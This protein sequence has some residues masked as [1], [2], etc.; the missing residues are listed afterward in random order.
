MSLK[1]SFLTHLIFLLVQP[2]S[3]G[4]I[5]KGDLKQGERDST[6]SERMKERHTQ[7][8]RKLS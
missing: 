8:F 6:W 2:V 5:S 4:A 3:L 1:A 7:S